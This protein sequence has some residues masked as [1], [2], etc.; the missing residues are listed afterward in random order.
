[1][2]RAER[3]TGGKLSTDKSSKPLFGS[4]T[5]HP[6]ARLV[7]TK[8]NYGPKVVEELVRSLKDLR[9]VVDLGAGGGEISASSA[10]TIPAQL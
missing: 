1:M 7:D 6:L 9:I 8:E 4:T 2:R 10:G 3:T 5:T